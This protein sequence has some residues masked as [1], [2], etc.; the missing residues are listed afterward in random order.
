MEEAI[1]Y[2]ISSH[3][4]II[5]DNPLTIEMGSVENVFRNNI[6]AYLNPNFCQPFLAE[7]TINKFG[8]LNYENI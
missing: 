5:D 6:L 1:Q 2:Y 8:E 4:L 7:K 3:H